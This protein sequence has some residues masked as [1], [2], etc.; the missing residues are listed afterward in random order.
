MR[1]LLLV[2]LFT[3]L[4]LALAGSASATH[5][6]TTCYIDSSAGSDS[7]SGA[8]TSLPWAHLPGMANATGLAASQV[9]AA[10]DVYYQPSNIF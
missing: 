4:V 9:P 1:K 8:S 7:N 6:C 2:L 10:G 3:M 5:T